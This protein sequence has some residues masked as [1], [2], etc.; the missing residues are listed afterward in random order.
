MQ[1]VSTLIPQGAEIDHGLARILLYVK[2]RH[3]YSGKL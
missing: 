1:N 2:A 3:V